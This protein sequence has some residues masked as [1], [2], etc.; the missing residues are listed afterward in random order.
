VEIEALLRAG[1]PDVPGLCLALAD[2]SAELRIVE[3]AIIPA[4]KK[5]RR[6]RSRA[7][8]RTYVPRLLR[9]RVNPLAV[10]TLGGYDR[11]PHLLAERAADESPD[12]VSLPASSFHGVHEQ[13]RL[14]RA[15]RPYVSV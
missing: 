15:M 6:G 13:M 10:P 7:G 1:H 14:R 4:S 3:R 8:E 11:Q 2:W 12:R 5:A 9:E